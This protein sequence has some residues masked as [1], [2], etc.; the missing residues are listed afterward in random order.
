MENVKYLTNHEIELINHDIVNVKIP[1]KLYYMEGYNY[2]F[3]EPPPNIKI[4][5]SFT[6][7]K[8]ETN[9]ETGESKEVNYELCERI[10]YNYATD[11]LSI[12]GVKKIYLTFCAH[13][14]SEP[15]VQK[16]K[17][18]DLFLYDN[19]FQVQVFKQTTRQKFAILSNDYQGGFLKKPDFC[20][21]T[22]NSHGNNF[23]EL[24]RVKNCLL[25]HKKEEDDRVHY[26]E[27]HLPDRDYLSYCFICDN[28]DK[29]ICVNES[30]KNSRYLRHFFHEEIPD[31]FKKI[32]DIDLTNNKERKRVC[33]ACS[34]LKSQYI[35]TTGMMFCSSKMFRKFYKTI[36]KVKYNNVNVINRVNEINSKQSMSGFI[37][38]SVFSKLDKIV[39]CVIL[40][41]MDNIQFLHDGG[42]L[43]EKENIRKNN[44]ELIENFKE[45]IEINIGN[46][47][48]GI[49][50]KI[51]RLVRFLMQNFG[52]NYRIELN[53]YKILKNV[54]ISYLSQVESLKFKRYN[55]K[56]VGKN[57]LITVENMFE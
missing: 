39:T 26:Q 45:E 25:C 13:Y 56:V 12:N 11:I 57:N 38:D 34:K 2:K 27:P 30:C 33:V 4:P 21:D 35:K 19:T 16:T 36:T 15:I 24:T 17:L 47:L 42:D 51:R 40:N 23:V 7:E 48:P 55:F 1:S 32:N 28:S 18:H 44:E 8:D 10:R 22:N 29:Y 49:L 54:N 9:N 3:I 41:L 14:D 6:I 50:M 43:V 37:S 53:K 20:F 46:E 31:E 52:N 5:K